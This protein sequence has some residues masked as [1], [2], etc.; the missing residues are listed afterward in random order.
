MHYDE[1]ALTLEIVYRGGRGRYRYFGVP[2]WEWTAFQAAE[3]KGTYLN[4]V[5]K[6]HGYRYEK[7]ASPS[8]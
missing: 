3:S 8:S 7:L 4:E 5:F 1:T 6:T 2:A